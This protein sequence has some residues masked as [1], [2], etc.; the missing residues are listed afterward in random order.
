MPPPI[1]TGVPC[2]AKWAASSRARLGMSHPLS[3]RIT[4]RRKRYRS[5]S[6]SDFRSDTFGCVGHFADCQ[7][8]RSDL[9]GDAKKLVENEAELD[10][11]DPLRAAHE[12]RGLVAQTDEELLDISERCDRNIRKGHM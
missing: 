5:E 7:Q 12:G 10:C 1:I 9:A 6:F 4:L 8:P 11:P 2:V 3:V